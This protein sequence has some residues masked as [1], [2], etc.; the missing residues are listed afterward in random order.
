MTHEEYIMVGA[1]TQYGGSF[2][3][4]LAECIRK[5]DPINRAKL[6]LAFPELWEKYTEMGLEDIDA[7]KI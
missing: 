4:A 2:A 6:K 7:N 3:V 5:A 1:M